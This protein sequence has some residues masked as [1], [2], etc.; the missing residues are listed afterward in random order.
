MEH[1]LRSEGIE[2]LVGHDMSMF[3]MGSQGELSIW[4]AK[5]DEERACRLLEQLEEEMSEA[6]EAGADES[7][8]EL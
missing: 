1:L 8:A 5:K 3:V 7:E 6:L 2:F 4:V